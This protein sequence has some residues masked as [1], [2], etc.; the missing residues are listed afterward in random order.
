MS[1]LPHS[2]PE[3]IRVYM[4]FFGYQ[5]QE[6]VVCE[7]TGQPANDIH[8]VRGRGKGKNVIRNL[9]ALT[10]EKHIDCHAERIKKDE[11]QE[12]HDRFIANFLNK[13]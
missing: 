5:I 13:V 7:I 1:S 3:H 10:D 4:E 8:H 6:D 9:M 12:I 2:I 11:A